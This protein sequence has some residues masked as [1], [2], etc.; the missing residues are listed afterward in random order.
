MGNILK[1][2]KTMRFLTALGLLLFVVY[3]PA[4]VIYERT[5]P[6]EFPSIQ[7][8]IELSDLSTFSLGDNN[9]C[10]GIGSRHIDRFGI[11]MEE[12]AFWAEAFSSGTNWIGHD[13][14]LIWAEEGSYD[15]GPDSLRAYIW[16]PGEIQK[17]LSVDIRNQLGNSHRYGVYLYS[18]KRLV[19]EKTDMLYTKNLQNNLVDDSLLIPGLSHIVAFENTILVFSNE[20]N[21]VLLDNQLNKVVTWEDTSALEFDI[22]DAVVFDSFLVGNSSVMPTRIALVNVYTEA[23]QALDLAEYLDQINDIQVNKVH[24]FVEG[25]LHNIPY[26]LQWDFDFQGFTVHTVEFPEINFELMYRYFPDRVYAW[27][28]DG[29]SKYRANYRMSYAYTNPLPIDYIDIGLDT[30]WVDSVD[31]HLHYY[32]VMYIKAVVSNH[33]IQPIYNFTM[34]YELIPEYFCDTGVYGGTFDNRDIPPGAK[35]T[36]SLALFTYPFVS[37]YSQRFYVHHG[38]YHLDDQHSNNDFN[39]VYVL[40]SS[41]EP[42]SSPYV[43]YPNP[44]SDAIAI[45]NSEEPIALELFNQTGQK[46]TT[47]LGRLDN[48]GSLA[49]GMYVLYS[50]SSSGLFIHKVIK[51]K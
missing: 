41:D 49:P 48:L 28:L 36:V 13:S 17:I 8:P 10:G 26:V 39:L 43:V 12:H 42:S 27:G 21:T 6:F 46:I 5:Y 29:L 1:N 20:G 45:L 22:M 15:V 47:G 33:S 31:T 40:S 4:Q 24:L 51:S 34:H 9:E 18:P 44:F 11:E 3:L 23:R 37:T 50:F 16:T 14:I 25:T 38:N 30:I 7:Y 35:D 19:F 2:K 32:Y